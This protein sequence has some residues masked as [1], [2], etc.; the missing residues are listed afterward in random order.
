M[1]NPTIVLKDG[2]PYLGSVSIGAA[3][4]EVNVENLLSVLEFGLNPRTAVDQPQ[5]RKKWPVSDPL[6]LPAGEFST[7]LVEAL[8]ARRLEV[9]AVTDLSL[10]SPAGSWAGVRFDSARGRW[11]AGLTR[12]RKGWAIGT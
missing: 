12:Q 4:H 7:P 9:D 5:I 1:G 3:F 8:R 2:R 6:H 11:Q 10:A